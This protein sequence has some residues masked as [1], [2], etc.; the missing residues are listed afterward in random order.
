MK[1]W[2]LDIIESIVNRVTRLEIRQKRRSL[3]YVRARMI[4]Y[5]I[6]VKMTKISITSIGK[7]ID[8]DHATVLYN[9]KNFDRDILM[10]ERYNKIYQKCLL[11][12]SR[13]IS[14]YDIDHNELKTIESLLKENQELKI[15]LASNVKQ[16]TRSDKM[17]EKL[18]NIFHEMDLSVKLDLI[19]K[20]K[21]ILK[22]KQRLNENTTNVRRV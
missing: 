16:M 19:Q 15:K 21:T 5:K 9:L 13:I 6:S 20:A 12:A 11:D 14:D 1:D 8:F 18:L 4:Y 22:V 7:F 10:D 17:E 2:E 3:D